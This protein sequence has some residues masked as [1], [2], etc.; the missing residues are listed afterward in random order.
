MM[1]KVSVIVPNYNHAKYLHKRLESIFNQTYQDFEVILLDDCSTDGSRE[2]LEQYRNHPKV[3]QLIYNKVNSGTSYKQWY[4]GINYANGELIWIAESDD[5]CDLRFLEVL[6]HHFSDPN[7]VI[8]YTDTLLFSEVDEIEFGQQIQINTSIKYDGNMFIRE[9]M[10]IG[11]SIVNASM[12]LLRKSRFNEVKDLGFK[13]MKLCGDWLL[14]MQIMSGYSLVH[15]PS[16]LNYCRRHSSNAAN[17]FG[18]MGYDLLEGLLVYKEGM[19]IVQNR[20]D[21]KKTYLGWLQRYVV[22][23]KIFMRF[24]NLKVL[25]NIYKMEKELFCFILFK[26]NKYKIK[27]IYYK[28]KGIG[29][30]K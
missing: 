1:P 26:Y 16:K 4:N 28:L 24:V 20:F 14:W 25:F 23:K 29:N 21:K 12:V 13:D 18:R 3:S 8:A 27:K 5:W 30:A 9:R 19:R 7:I 17:R 10:L 22:Y 2:I 6:V 15:I 11:N